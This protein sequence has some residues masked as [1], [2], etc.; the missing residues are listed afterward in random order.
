M[1]VLIAVF[2]QNYFI[3]YKSHEGF[4]KPD[5]ADSAIILAPHVL[6]SRCGFTM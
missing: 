5:P 6:I 2:L 3:F 4:R 1:A